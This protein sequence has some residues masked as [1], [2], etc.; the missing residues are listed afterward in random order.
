MRRVFHWNSRI[1]RLVLGYALLVPAFGVILFT[2]AYP[3]GNSI[4][5]SFHEANFLKSITA[6]PFV[7]LRNYLTVFS[8]PSF[9]PIF[10]EAVTN[11]FYLTFT[12]VAISFFVGFGIALLLHQNIMAR[13]IWRSALIMPWLVP[14]VSTSLL[15]MWIMD[16]QW[17]V[18][19]VLL[20]SLGL[21]DKFLKWFG[22]PR[23]AMPT[24]MAMN[25]WKLYPFVMV[26]LL[27]GLQTISVDLLD[28]ARID[29]ANRA[30]I[31]RFVILPHLRSVIVVVTLM[32]IIW[33]FQIF[34]PIWLITQGG[35]INVTTTLAILTYK[36]A[37][38]EFDF[39][40]AT[41]V[42]TLWLLFLILFS[43][44]WTK[45]IGERG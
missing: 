32:P 35:P 1:R 2:V 13:G 10:R 27:A 16:P 8:D 31:M 30:Q 12:S 40:M 25:V 29:G 41:T 20:R 36:K 15:W 28:A 43:I 18:F 3:L 34:T 37:F 45:L 24:M 19:N 4:W 7:G 39:G 11:S 22:D 5:T 33:G 44:A 21:I 6:R 26:M 42:G 9:T 14:W 38:Y 23:L 17:G